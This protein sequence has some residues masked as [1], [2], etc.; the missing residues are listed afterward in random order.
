MR[1]FSQRRNPYVFGLRPKLFLEQRV[2]MYVE[3]L[4]K[5]KSKKQF[6]PSWNQNSKAA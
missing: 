6:N 5:T 4:K 1:T 2:E 3:D